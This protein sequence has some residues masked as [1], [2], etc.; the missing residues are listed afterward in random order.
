MT[1]LFAARLNRAMGR[2]FVMFAS[3]VMFEIGA[4]L[5][6]AAEHY[7]MLILGRIFLGIAVGIPKIHALDTLH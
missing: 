4:I 3:G 6:A 5:L 2:K 1:L 7:V